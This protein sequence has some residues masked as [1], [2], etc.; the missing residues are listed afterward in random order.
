MQWELKEIHIAPDWEETSTLSLYCQTT[1]LCKNSHGSY[2]KA[3]RPNCEFIKFTEYKIKNC[4]SIYWQQQQQQKKRLDIETLKIPFKIIENADFLGIKLK[5]N[6]QDWYVNIYKSLLKET[7]EDL[8]K[9]K[10]SNLPQIHLQIQC[11]P[12]KIPADYFRRY[13]L[14]DSKIHVKM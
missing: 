7:E 1:W 13:W 4:V 9:W 6:M 11:N 8:S 10:D 14:A 3:V 2:Q 12:I 5:T